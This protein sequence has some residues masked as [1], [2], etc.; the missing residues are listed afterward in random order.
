ML[1]Q[2][3]AE[4]RY[5]HS[6]VAIVETIRF[7]MQLRIPIGLDKE[8]C[9][10]EPEIT[11]HNFTTPNSV[12]FWLGLPSDPELVGYVPLLTITA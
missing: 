1:I 9:N 8:I 5:I 10:N 2:S 11:D 6:I 4:K 3:P 7:A 12:G